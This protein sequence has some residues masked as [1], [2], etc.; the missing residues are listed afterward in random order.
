MRIFTRVA[1]AEA[2]IHGKTVEEV[3]FHEVGAVDSIVDIVGCAILIHELQPQKIYASAVREGH[4]FVQ[5]R[6][7]LL[8]VP[9]PA[10]CEILAAANAP[11]RQIDVEGELV[12]PTGAA[13][14][15]ELA[16]SFGTMPEMR[17][18]KI[19]WGA[20][21]KDI[22]IPNVLKVYQGLRTPEVVP[23]ADFAGQA[24][25]LRDQV[26]VLEANIDDCTGEMLGYALQVLLDAGALDVSCVPIYMKKNRPAYRLT[27]LARPGDEAKME[28]LI[29]GHTTTIGI[30]R[31]VEERSVLK[32]ES[33]AV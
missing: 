14:I 28:K 32:R 10:T 5:C 19:G 17:L 30:R 23:A 24:D 25:I 27:V 12:T 31:R 15:A 2:K 6:H 20:G 1:K 22:S 13:I 3:H 7:G 9:V 11:L 21:T 16:S 4:G 29:F 18:E 26:A 8:P 33:A